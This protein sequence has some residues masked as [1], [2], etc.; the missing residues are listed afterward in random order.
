M[1]GCMTRLPICRS[2]TARSPLLL[3]PPDAEPRPS[4][5]V[6]QIPVSVSAP[7]CVVPRPSARGCYFPGHTSWTLTRTCLAFDLH[8][9]PAVW[10]VT[11]FS[12]QWG[13][14]VWE[15]QLCQW[16]QA[17]TV[18][19]CGDCKGANR[20][21]HSL[22]TGEL[23]LLLAHMWAPAGSAAAGGCRSVP[24]PAGAAAPA[25]PLGAAS[26]PSPACIALSGSGYGRRHC[27]GQATCKGEGA[28]GQDHTPRMLI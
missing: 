4:A 22:P 23:L 27:L 24:G 18:V 16:L 7:G 14:A 15:S 21:S 8:W 3:K 13:T 28:A 25:E 20:E 17:A 11:W 1:P 2:A 12:K 19:D 10:A 26:H 9:P 6:Q 5:R